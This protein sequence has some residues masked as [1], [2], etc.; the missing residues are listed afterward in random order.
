MAAGCVPV[1]INKGGQAEIVE[2]G[3]TGFLW[4]TVA[5][6]KKYTQLLADDGSLWTSM[7]AAARQRAQEFSRERFLDRMSRLCG[8]EMRQPARVRAA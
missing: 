4:N 8:V 2:H 7:S 3:K 6:L 5:E 1:V